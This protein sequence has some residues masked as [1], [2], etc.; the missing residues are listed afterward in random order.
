[1]EKYQTI[2][3][4]DVWKKSKDLVRNIYEITKGFPQEE[5]YCL[6]S[7]IRKSAISIPSNV[8]EGCG[9]HSQ[10]DTVHFLHIARGSLFELETQLYIAYD[11][12]YLTKLILDDFLEKIAD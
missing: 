2:T 11:L 5:M 9:R 8:A 1:M 10:K 7:Q 12:N 4:L 3:D 6:T